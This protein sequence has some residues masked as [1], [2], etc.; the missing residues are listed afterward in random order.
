MNYKKQYDEKKTR[1]LSLLVR[2]SEFF[3]QADDLETVCTFDDL[4]RQVEN[5]EFSIVVVGEFSAGKSTFL[6]AMMGEKYLPSFSGET[7]ATVNFLKHVNKADPDEGLRV[8][9]HD[10]S[11]E[12]FSEASFDNI[13]RYA[14][15][16]GV[17]VASNIQQVELYLDSPLLNDDVI[18]V[19]SPG[20]NGV[21]EGHRKITE[22]QIKK[23]HACIFLFNAQAPGKNSE[24][25]FLDRLKGEVSTI[26][27]VLNKIDAI[28]SHEETI[29]SVVKTLSESYLSKFPNAET[30]PEIWPISAQ[31][32]L[33]ARSDQQIAKN[34]VA[35]ED[36]PSYLV[37]SR[38]EQF[39]QRL[40]R[41][42]T[43]GEKARSEL[44]EPVNRVI[45]LLEKARKDN[46]QL[47]LELQES[48]S[49]D[50]VLQ[51]IDA[52]EEQ[53]EK[54]A[55]T[56]ESNQR[57]IKRQVRQSR[58]A[59]ENTMIATL[60]TLR[61]R[62]VTK[63]ENDFVNDED[64]MLSDDHLFESLTKFISRLEDDVNNSV[65]SFAFSFQAEL[66][67]NI[68]SMVDIELDA[69]NEAFATLSRPI[70]LNSGDLLGQYT[71]SLDYAESERR[72]LELEHEIELLEEHLSAAELAGKSAVKLTHKKE[73]LQARRQTLEDEKRARLAEMGPI[74]TKERYEKEVTSR[75]RRGGLL[76][77]AWSGLFG[78]KIVRDTEIV[79]DDSR[80]V[81]F[82]A[83]KE[84]VES[85]YDDMLDQMNAEL[86][87]IA[88][89]DVDAAHSACKML[90]NKIR[91]LE[92]KKRQETATFDA[93]QQRHFRTELKRISAD[94]EESIDRVRRE[95][96]D[97]ISRRLR[98]QES[99]I[100]PLLSQSIEN[101]LSDKLRRKKQ[102]LELKKMDLEGS[103]TEKAD[104]VAHCEEQNS[105]INHLLEAAIDVQCDLES[106]SV[107]VIE[108]RTVSELC[109]G[110]Q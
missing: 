39:E 108:C 20:L 95:A 53:L 99:A 7:T 23:S 33:I 109:E 86:D 52:L 1:V 91:M 72:R 48:H 71:L 101:S 3:K 97:E 103:I 104:R 31:D 90:N 67:A 79:E 66:E 70:D 62:Y 47:I 16:R 59:A 46:S 107:D 45:L 15:T 57:A 22:Q 21:R 27:L 58:Q 92:E 50:D 26:L 80:S 5:G 38:L 43:Q 83:H 17:E 64:R 51:Q 36:K 11:S 96:L 106:Q 44:L 12:S 88:D 75:E 32:A 24:F 4:H 56:V 13:E 10:G 102:E 18:L 63:F 65:A 40:W 19:D 110:V 29:E 60:D 55:E 94:I 14:T 41:F 76:G 28:N 73:S 84:K 37:R 100:V 82:Q 49:K 9:Y 78:R 98:S 77:W 85:H 54:I 34:Q 61:E 74:P 68:Q 93:K 35:A 2:A 69:I 25:E 30:L 81:Q 105:L 42:L 8:V 87:G 6:N 89:H